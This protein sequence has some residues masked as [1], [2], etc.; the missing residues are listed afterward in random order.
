MVFDRNAKAVEAL[1]RR[2]A[3]RRVGSLEEMVGKLDA[4]R[5][6]WVMLPAGKITEDTVET[7]GS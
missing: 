2:T 5:V 7:L 6:V 3:R 4:P 1:G